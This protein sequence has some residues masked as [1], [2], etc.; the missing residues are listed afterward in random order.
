MFSSLYWERLERQKQLV[1]LYE[2]RMREMG[3]GRTYWFKNANRYL[4][5]MITGRWRV[6]IICWRWWALSAPESSS[7]IKR[8]L[9]STKSLHL[10][11]VL[12]GTW[13]T[14]CRYEVE[15]TFFREQ[16]VFQP[17]KVEL[18]NACHRVDVMISPIIHQWI[19]S[20]VHSTH[21]FHSLII[22]H[23]QCS[24]NTALMQFFY[25]Y[26]KLGGWYKH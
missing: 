11:D 19:L 6:T 13:L 20:Y 23:Y 8:K 3:C 4:M 10:S 26:F 7:E 12:S 25:A 21:L 16:R 18:K 5:T 14:G 2:C 24:C 1:S 17:P 15:E 22:H 9:D